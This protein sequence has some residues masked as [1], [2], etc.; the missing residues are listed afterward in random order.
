MASIIITN[1]LQKGDYYPL[2]APECVIGRSNACTIQVLDEQVSRQHMQIVHDPDKNTY[3]SQDLRS[4]HGIYINGKKTF[5]DTILKE[6]DQITIGSATLLF[7]LKNFTD[8]QAA[9]AYFMQA[10]SWNLPTVNEPPD[11]AQGPLPFGA[12]SDSFHIAKTKSF[13][14][15]AGADRLTLAIVF[16]D[17]VDSTL[18]IHELGDEY[19][20]NIRNA[21]F[22]RAR[23]LISR[24]N[25]YEIKTIGDE[26]MVACFTSTNALDFAWE[27]YTDTGAPQLKIRAGIHVGPVAIEQ[28]DAHGATVNYAARVMNMAEQGGLWISND[29]KN[30]IN[31]E[32]AQR[33]QKLNWRK[34]EKSTLKG[35]PGEHTLWSLQQDA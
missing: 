14:K 20:S 1:G 19:Y 21:H 11:T 2:E 33:H 22:Q 16:T 24:L 30:H 5:S 13:S 23:S 3:T 9:L 17:I 32:K 6:G 7:T 34:H 8:R 27:L 28:N 15:W 29:I 10:Q 18:L 25:G 4:T 26:F 35:F 12:D 31:Q